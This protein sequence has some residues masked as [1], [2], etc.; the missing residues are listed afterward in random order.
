MHA[1]TTFQPVKRHHVVENP[2]N[3]AVP[4]PNVS[5]PVTGALRDSS[6]A[7]V[8]YAPD[9]RIL[10]WNRGAEQLYGYTED[11]ALGMRIDALVPADELDSAHQFH[12]QILAGDRPPTQ[13]TRRRCHDG[14][15][16]AVAVT[17]SALVNENGEAYGIATIER[18]VN[19][20]RVA[21]NHRRLALLAHEERLMVAGEMAAGLAHE[22]NQ[23]L[24]A[25]MQ[26]CDLAEGIA[27]S[28]RMRRRPE[29]TE[30]LDDINQQAQRAGD[31][32]VSLRRF[33]GRSEAV[34]EARNINDVIRET[35]G[36]TRW[37]LEHADASLHLDLAEWLPPVAIDRTQIEQVL[38]NLIRNASEAME[39]AN[40]NP[41]RIIIESALATPDD[42]SAVHVT[43]RD[44][45]P[46][47]PEQLTKL[48]FSPFQTTKPNGLGLGLWISRSIIEAH[49]GR[50]W[51]DNKGPGSAFHFILR[52]DEDS[53]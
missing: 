6:D 23:P 11:Q 43:V 13:Y 44:T 5:S 49:G 20:E 7:I 33:L 19:L 32:V 4:Q 9:G 8:M 29:L 51:F 41:R 18:D 27:R 12:R 2:E 36:F 1:L 15:T 14:H 35:A 48:L 45:G 39:D 26:F 40:S 31:I 24:S 16:L 37:S 25:I 21:E 47:I 53:A 28:T 50:L 34:R 10:A 42:A 22:L 3:E 52:V 17:A 38:V 30:A 46:G